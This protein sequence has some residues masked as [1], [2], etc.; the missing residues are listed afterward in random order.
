M[1]I[2]EFVSHDLRP[3][4]RGVVLCYVPEHQPYTFAVHAAESWEKDLTIDPLTYLFGEIGRN[5]SSPLV[6]IL[7]GKNRD[8]HY[9]RIHIAAYD[10]Y[11]QPRLFAAGSAT[12]E[13]FDV[14]L[15]DL[16]E[17]ARSAGFPII[18]QLAYGEQFVELCRWE[19]RYPFASHAVMTA[20][21]AHETLRQA[22]FE[23]EPAEAGIRIFRD[24]EAPGKLQRAI[25][26]AVMPLSLLVSKRA[27]HAGLRVVAG[28]GVRRMV[29][30]SPQRF[31]FDLIGDPVD[32]AIELTPNQLLAISASWRPNFHPDETPLE[33]D[34]P[35]VVAVT[36]MGVDKTV[37]LFRD[38]D[39]RVAF[40]LRDALIHAMTPR[41]P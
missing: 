39:P 16:L 5:S 15:R 23:V 18:E 12:A 33:S 37:T 9:H 21:H 11:D 3:W 17:Q 31:H 19:G 32:P 40:A 22:G 14:L 34:A 41:V 38:P 25:T 35:A 26:A 4:A 7:V 27:R 24:E 13:D 8:R 30:A 20:A 28:K 36:A 2:H 6:T 29:E 1:E 10:R